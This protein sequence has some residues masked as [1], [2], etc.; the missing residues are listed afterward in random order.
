MIFY[1]FHPFINSDDANTKIQ[2]F[3]QFWENVHTTTTYRFHP[4]INSDDANTKI[5]PFG[6][7]WE[8]TGSNPSIGAFV[9]SITNPQILV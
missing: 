6:R 4:F 1:I 9:Q 3:G 8:N 7:L 5:Q 2:P